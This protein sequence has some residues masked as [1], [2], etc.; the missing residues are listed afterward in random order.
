MIKNIRKWREFERR[1]EAEQPVDYRANYRIFMELMEMA[2]KM[3]VWPPSD[4]LEGLE[5]DIKVARLLN[6]FR[7]ESSSRSG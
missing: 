4:P 2:R 5:V 7:Y 6:R 3:G 1:W